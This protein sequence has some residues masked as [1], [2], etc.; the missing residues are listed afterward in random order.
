M[1]SC[2]ERWGARGRAA[3]RSTERKGGAS[4]TRARTAGRV[5]SGGDGDGEPGR[6][7]GLQQGSKDEGCREEPSRGLVYRSRGQDRVSG[8]D[9][10]C[11]LLDELLSVDVP[12]S[13]SGRPW[14]P[15]SSRTNAC[16]CLPADPRPF[17]LE[18]LAQLLKKRTLGASRLSSDPHLAPL[19]LG[20]PLATRAARLATMDHST[21]DHLARAL[22]ARL[23]QLPQ[24][25]GPFDP[26]SVILK[27]YPAWVAGAVGLG[28]LVWRSAGLL[29]LAVATPRR[30]LSLTSSS[31]CLPPQRLPGV[32]GLRH[33]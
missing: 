32:E 21:P 3:A 12:A 17:S 15:T 22:A 2:F 16:A 1:L 19:P 5:E 4:R 27:T 8:R 14:R 23:R 29:P 26:L 18:Q 6:V 33:R 7:D 20:L 25:L 11:W 24:T 31:P 9:G 28:A 10:R 30:G 13:P